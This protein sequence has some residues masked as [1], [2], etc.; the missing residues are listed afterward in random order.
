[1]GH[2]TA[3]LRSAR[4]LVC[5]RGWDDLTC[6]AGTLRAIVN[7]L[8]PYPPILSQAMLRKAQMANAAFLFLPLFV[9]S[10]FSSPLLPSLTSL[11]LPTALAVQMYCSLVLVTSASSCTYLTRQPQAMPVPRPVL[12]LHFY[13][14]CALPSCAR[15]LYSSLVLRVV[16][17]GQRVRAGG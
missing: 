9:H 1:M 5:Y 2:P 7:F 16:E 3:C 17:S 14:L 11:L 4:E 8:L 6:L 13:Y 10:L 12:W 15:L